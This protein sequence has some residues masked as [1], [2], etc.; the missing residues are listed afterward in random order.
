M[1][2]RN[3]FINSG[4]TLVETMIALLVVLVVLLGLI[5]V[6]LLSIDANMK[7][8][9]RDEAVQLAGRRMN[10]ARNTAFNSLVSDTGLLPSDAK[11]TKFRATFPNG[12]RVRKDIRNIRDFDFCTNM[13]VQPTAVTGTKQI[14][15]TV[16]WEWKGLPTKHEIVSIVRR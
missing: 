5:Q 4:F 13:T 16:G 10:D 1:E 14:T 7:N 11:C 6:S 8:V 12:V 9:L 3:A 15:I 2:A